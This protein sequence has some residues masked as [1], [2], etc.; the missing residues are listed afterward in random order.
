MKVGKGPFQPV[1]EQFVPK[2][3][4]STC[5]PGTWLTCAV[6]VRGESHP[7]SLRQRAVGRVYP[8]LAY[9]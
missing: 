6:L 3:C 7:V 4:S 1:Q 9:S 8:F 5:S 2:E